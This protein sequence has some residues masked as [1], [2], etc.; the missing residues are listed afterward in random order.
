MLALDANLWIAA[1]DPADVFHAD[2]VAVF[3]EAARFSLPLAGPSLVVLESICALARRVG[4]PSFAHAARAQMGDHPALHLE[5]ISDDL[6]AEAVRLG[7]E[8][9]LRGIDAL[10]M[11]TARRLGC[12]LLSWDQE[13]IDRGGALSPRGWLATIRGDQEQEPAPAG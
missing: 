6:L 11:A 12:P 9:R 13:L 8:H 4:D 1:F 7:V 2:S 10:Y 5:P 3:A